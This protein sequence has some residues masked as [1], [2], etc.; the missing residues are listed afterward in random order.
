M[1]WLPIRKDFQCRMCFRFVS[2]AELRHLVN[3]KVNLPGRVVDHNSPRDQ[4]VGTSHQQT[5][6][7]KREKCPPAMPHTANSQPEETRHEHQVRE[8]GDC[9]DFSGNL[10]NEGE[11]Q[12]QNAARNDGNTNWMAA[13]KITLF[14]DPKT[15][16][17]PPECSI[18]IENDMGTRAH[19]DASGFM[20]VERRIVRYSLLHTS[21]EELQAL[22]LPASAQSV[23][24]PSEPR[25]GRWRWGKEPTHKIREN[26]EH[27]FP[28]ILA[29]YR[30]SRVPSV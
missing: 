29:E 1:R 28:D 15:C 5:E 8:V 27:P 19:H 25:Q 18:E 26:S 7:E 12:N 11:F 23:A 3:P 6:R 10:T 22:L 16:R 24:P 21:D 20:P 17:T 9:L 13:R 14:Q 30:T 2:I 4:D